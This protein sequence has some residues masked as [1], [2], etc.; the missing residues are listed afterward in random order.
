MPRAQKR[1]QLANEP[2]AV[3]DTPVAL[4][5]RLHRARL[6]ELQPVNDLIVAQRV[7]HGRGQQA[8]LRVGGHRLACAAQTRGV[9]L[10]EPVPVLFLA[11]LAHIARRWNGAFRAG[12]RLL[13]VVIQQS[14]DDAADGEPYG[15][16]NVGQETRNHGHD[17]AR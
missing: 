9:V 1:I 17:C 11:G 13:D 15:E 10:V 12:G 6:R 3:R 7:H 2:L 16:G 4:Q 14:H 5:H 8:R